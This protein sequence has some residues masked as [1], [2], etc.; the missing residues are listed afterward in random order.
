MRRDLARAIILGAV[1]LLGYA[2]NSRWN[3]SM[4]GWREACAVIGGVIFV[5]TLILLPLAIIAAGTR[6]GRRRF[7]ARS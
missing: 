7:A 4:G 3:T 1:L 6:L 5:S 2:M